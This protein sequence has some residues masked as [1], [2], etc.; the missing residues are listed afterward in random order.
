MAT[1]PYLVKGIDLIHDEQRY[2]EGER[3]DLGDDDA[4]AMRRWLEPLP[5]I[6]QDKATKQT[7]S[8]DKKSADKQKDVDKDSAG[9]GTD[10]DEGDKQ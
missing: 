1:K 10:K 2:P 6:L 9:D 7:E 4:K 8:N 3:I 5:H